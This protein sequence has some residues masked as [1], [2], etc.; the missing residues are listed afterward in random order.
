MMPRILWPH[1]IALGE[2]VQIAGDDGHHFARVLRSQPGEQIA[3]AAAN[4]PY[5]AHIAQVDGKSG[6]ID[7]LVESILPSHEPSTSIYLV[8]GLAKG[9]K[10]EEVV[11]KCT[12]A[13]VAGILVYESE[14]SVVRLGAAKAAAKRIRWQRVAAEAASQSQRDRV[15]DVVYAAH[16]ATVA[17]W[18]ADCDIDVRLVLDEDEQAQ[19]L[20]QTLR[21]H[22]IG[23][24]DIGHDERSMTDRRLAIFVGP[25]G[26]WSDAERGLFR[27]RLRAETITLGP[28]ILR[29]ETAGL[30]A[31]SAILFACGEMGG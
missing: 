15:P 4:G 9:D 23:A 6:T 8:Q 10:I 26:G 24:A 1:P 27:D 3:L 16:V 30:T 31:L 22:G 28:R 12:E 20:R 17:D 7:V 2:R 25:E 19:S 21:K 18:L 5:L 13:G 14:R 11:Q 29:T